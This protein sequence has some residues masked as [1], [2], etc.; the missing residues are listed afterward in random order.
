MMTSERPGEADRR[1]KWFR[2]LD[3][4][5]AV[6]PRNRR[7]AIHTLGLRLT[8]KQER[9]LLTMVEVWAQAEHARYQ[10]TPREVL[11]RE[12]ERRGLNR[13]FEPHNGNRNPADGDDAA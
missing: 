8:S 2:L 13:W 11:G 1:D 12:P 3:T 5:A 7:A 9:L 4:L 10:P 6:A